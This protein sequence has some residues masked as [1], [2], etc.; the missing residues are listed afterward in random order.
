MRPAS[1]LRPGATVNRVKLRYRAAPV[2][3]RL[4]GDPRP[5]SH[6]HLVI[7]LDSPVDGAAPGQTACLMWNESV[8][9]WGTIAQPEEPPVATGAQ[10][11]AADAA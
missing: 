9:G 7:E 11:E 3:C 10:M 8:V 5:G 6:D 4:A 2:P 1:L